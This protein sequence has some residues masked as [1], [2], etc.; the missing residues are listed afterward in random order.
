LNAVGARVMPRSLWI[1]CSRSVNSDAAL[2]WELSMNRILVSALSLALVASLTTACGSKQNTEE[3]AV[4]EQ[5]VEATASLRLI[6]AAAAPTATAFLND[7]QLGGTI[8]AGS[9][10]G[11]LDIPVGSRTL[12]V[13]AAD[14]TTELASSRETFAADTEYTV[15]VGGTA[16]NLMVTVLGDAV[17]TLAEGQSFVRFVNANAAAVTINQGERAV[18]DGLAPGAATN[19]I[20]MAPESYRFEGTSGD[21]A[22]GLSISVNPG[23]VYLVTA[24]S[25]GSALA[26]IVTTLR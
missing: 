22:E 4:T 20:E 26:Y 9:E 17:P 6:H 15:V 14:G 23:H 11:P 8:S 16:S 1:F 21:L 2:C 18:A 5:T 25:T 7:T 13:R 3:D 24:Y 12:S 10:A 19:F